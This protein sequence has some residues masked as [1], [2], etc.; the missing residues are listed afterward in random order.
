MQILVVFGNNF[1]SVTLTDITK[2]P[3]F[4]RK[5]CAFIATIRA[6]SGCATS[7]KTV[8]TIPEKTGRK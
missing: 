1:L 2:C 7:A 8:S 4:F 3:P 5:E 6:W